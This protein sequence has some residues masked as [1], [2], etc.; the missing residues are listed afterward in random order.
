[1]RTDHTPGQTDLVG[2][3]DRI[4]KCREAAGDAAGFGVMLYWHESIDVEAALR[5]RPEGGAL[6]ECQIKRDALA[7]VVSA[8]SGKLMLEQETLVGML[9]QAEEELRAKRWLS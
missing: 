7:L 6:E 5:A 3:A 9:R 4:K 2:I 1:M 8:L